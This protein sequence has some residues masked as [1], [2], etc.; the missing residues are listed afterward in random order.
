MPE[1]PEV[2]T[3]RRSLEPL[4]LG[5]K[6]L[7]IRWIH[8]PVFVGGGK[9]YQE[10]LAGATFIALKRKGK[11]LRFDFD[12]GYSLYSHLRMEGKYFFRNEGEPF[13]KHDLAF[14]ALDNGQTLCYNDTRKF[15]RFHLGRTSESQ[16][17]SP[18]AEIGPE[19]FDIDPKE[20]W[21]GLKRKSISIKE[22]L[23]DQH[24]I[25]GI[26]NI[27]DC[28]IL[29]ATK[30]SP[31][32][33][34]NKITYKQA[35]DILSS[36]KEILTASIHEGGSTIRSYHPLDGIDG[37]M[38][39]QLKVYGKEGEPCL[40]CQ[41]PIRREEVAGRGTYFCPKCQHVHQKKEKTFV[42][43]VTG[44]IHSGKSSLSSLLKKKGY[45][46]F[47]ADKEVKKMYSSPLVLA[48]AKT[49]IGAK[50]IK[51]GKFDV[52]Y[53]RQAF[54]S[55]PAKKERWE[56]YLYPQV[57]KR[58]VS[59]ISSFEKGSKICLD[60]PL[61][62][63]AKMDSLCD[64]IILIDSPIKNRLERFSDDPKAKEELVRINSS[65]PLEETKNKATR[66]IENDGSI[67]DLSLQIRKLKLP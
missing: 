27:Y 6:V 7:S 56:R 36:A 21:N 11:C 51:N 37:L 39:L 45:K 47:D 23:L 22:A 55:S 15:G 57:K 52:A 9:I 13:S 35:Q 49:I 1:L 67:E 31:F 8:E 19:P 59:F 3:V 5:K 42:V 38:Q 24:L 40:L 58:A 26:G 12:N 61:L 41:T 43:G 34:A 20:F 66:V 2:E 4:L 50:A 46:V 60:V 30:I 32:T 54:A 44:P 29:F 14:F 16:L 53:V 28:E 65:Y 64:E 33:P 62:V 25:S 10:A 17:H 18:F 48:K 63:K